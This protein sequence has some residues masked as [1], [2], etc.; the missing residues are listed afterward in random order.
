MHDADSRQGGDQ[1]LAVTWTADDDV[2]LFVGWRKISRPS[3]THLSALAPSPVFRVVGVRH[4]TTQKE[5][6][7]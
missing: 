6:C 5:S 2:K 1:F 3:G 7:T 4:T